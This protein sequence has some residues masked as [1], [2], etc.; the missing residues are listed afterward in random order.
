MIEG[1]KMRLIHAVA[2]AAL[3]SLIGCASAPTLQTG[4][5]AEVTFDG[6]TRVDNTVMD[7]VWVRPGADLSGYQKVLLQGAGIEYRPVDRSAGVGFDSST[8]FPMTDSQKERLAEIV[9]EAFREEMERSERFELVDAPGPDVLLVHGALLDVVSRVPPQ[10]LGRSEVYLASVGEATLVVEARDG[11][12]GAILARAADR[13]AA[14]DISGRLTRAGAASTWSEVRF[15]A[16]RWAQQL[17][18][19]LEGLAESPI[20]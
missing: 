18:R 5:D 19:G 11:R 13:R 3:T 15:L 17:R 6:L 16:Q 9:Q 10:S 1:A 2:A 7:V 20:G 8:E 12:T 4:P 14:E